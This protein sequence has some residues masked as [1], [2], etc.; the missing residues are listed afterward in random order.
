MKVRFTGKT[1]PMSLTNGKVYEVISVERGWYRIYVDTADDDYL[2]PPE[3]LEITEGRAVKLEVGLSFIKNGKCYAVCT[4]DDIPWGMKVKKTSIA[5]HVFDVLEVRTS[6][7]PTGV[8][9]VGIMVDS[10]LPLQNGVYYGT[11]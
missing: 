3:L 7:S 9:L 4:G 2:F 1:E 10:K 11:I 5:S 8:I 6:K